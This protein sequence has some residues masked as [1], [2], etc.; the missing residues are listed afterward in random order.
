MYLIAIEVSIFG[1]QQATLVWYS[2]CKH[3]C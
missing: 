3:I 2:S 1:K